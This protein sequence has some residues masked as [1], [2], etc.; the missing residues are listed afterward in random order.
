ML[1]EEVK[2]QLAGIPKRCLSSCEKVLKAY[3]DHIISH[4]LPNTLFQLYT[5]KRKSFKDICDFLSDYPLQMR[6]SVYR[7]IQ[8]IG[9]DEIDDVLTFYKEIINR[10]DLSIAALLL[11]NMKK[12]NFDLFPAMEIMLKYDDHFVKEAIN[13]YISAFPE[14]EESS[15]KNGIGR[16]LLAPFAERAVRNSKNPYQTASNFLTTDYGYLASKI[17]YEFEHA[18]VTQVCSTWYFVNDVHVKRDF[19]EL[20]IIQKGF[21][22]ELNRAIA[23]ADDYSGKVKNLRQY[24][25]E[26]TEIVDNMSEELAVITNA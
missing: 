8:K 23:Q 12:R 21:F 11:M 7:S 1:E 26:V 25:R 6:D 9:A 4:E 16:D 13:D 3:E 10:E 15:V 14:A 17:E 19:E 2:K 5:T 22:E 20:E 24:C 18:E